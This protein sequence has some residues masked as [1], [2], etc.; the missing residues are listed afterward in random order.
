MKGRPRR[1]CHLRLWISHLGRQGACPLFKR[2][3]STLR[4]KLSLAVL[5]VPREPPSSCFQAAG[6]FLQVVLS[7]FR[8]CLCSF[9]VGSVIHSPGTDSYRC[10][11]SAATHKARRG[12]DVFRC[13]TRTHVCM[14]THTSTH[15]CTPHV[16]ARTHVHAGNTCSHN[17]SV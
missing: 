12:R 14:C 3:W 16:H 5:E 7:L 15:M 2:P 10:R 1:K 11:G 4:S 6:F 17:R 13:N 8:S 9:L